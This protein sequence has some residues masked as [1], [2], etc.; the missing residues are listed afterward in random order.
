MSDIF[1]VAIQV[2]G[3]DTFLVKAEDWDD[4]VTETEKEIREMLKDT[5]LTYDYEIDVFR[6]VV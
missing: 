3:T 1:E 4:A 6:K 5:G 2:R